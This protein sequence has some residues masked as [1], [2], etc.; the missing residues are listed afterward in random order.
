MSEREITNYYEHMITWMVKHP[1]WNKMKN[2]MRNMSDLSSKTSMVKTVRAEL[3]MHEMA[4]IMV[5]ISCLK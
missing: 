1:H 5:K 2:H 4:A 3:V